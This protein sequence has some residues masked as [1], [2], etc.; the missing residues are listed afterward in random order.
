MY[1][2]TQVP[3]S[4][5]KKLPILAVSTCLSLKNH[6]CKRKV[7]SG[8]P[9]S[10]ARKPFAANYKVE[11][12]GVA[13]LLKSIQCTFCFLPLAAACFKNCTD[14]ATTATGNFSNSNMQNQNLL[15]IL[16]E[17]G[18]RGQNIFSQEF[19]HATTPCKM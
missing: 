4:E 1:C 12:P 5:R 9:P 8:E 19:T 6:V 17:G 15:C 13:F 10:Q 11:E 14:Y 7:I 16:L 18:G 2:R 3:I